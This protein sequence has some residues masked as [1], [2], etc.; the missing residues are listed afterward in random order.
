MNNQFINK[1]RKNLKAIIFVLLSMMIMS[2]KNSYNELIDN[3]NKEF[4]SP[5][6]PVEDAYSVTNQGFDP[7]SMLD[8]YYTF[9]KGYFVNLEAPADALTY[10]WT[11]TGLYDTENPVTL[12]NKQYL[13]F[14]TA[15]AF[16]LKANENTHSFKLVLTITVTGAEG[17]VKEYIDSS[18]ITIIDQNSTGHGGF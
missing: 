9:K 17:T 3:F 8:E 16:N 15:E 6:R 18:T 1:I 2:C 5:E 14:N 7:D 10:L 11:Y 4:F 12:S 13:Y